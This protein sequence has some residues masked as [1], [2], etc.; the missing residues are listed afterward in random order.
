MIDPRQFKKAANKTPSRVALTKDPSDPTKVIA[1]Y[2][3]FNEDG[4][5]VS[6]IE[7]GTLAEVQAVLTE[8]NKDRNAL[9]ELEAAI[10]AL[11]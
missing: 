1:T 5:P 11:G 9:Q 4:D 10:I 6:H 7:T 3:R 2:Q 8:T